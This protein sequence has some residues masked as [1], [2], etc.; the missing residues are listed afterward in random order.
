MGPM[1]SAEALIIRDYCTNTSG[2]GQGN[3][4]PNPNDLLV[5]SR[6]TAGFC[7]DWI[8][9]SPKK[10]VSGDEA[11]AFPRSECPGL[12]AW[13]REGVIH[14]LA[15]STGRK[16]KGTEAGR[17]QTMRTGRIQRPLDMLVA[18]GPSTSGTVEYCKNFAG[19][20]A[21]ESPRFT[22]EK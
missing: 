16:V 18:M 15:A 20:S 21:S 11:F 13:H 2:D 4:C 10:L 19:L 17:K 5:R 8:C 1:L 6:D 12:A 22:R 3:R 9:C 7:G 14:S